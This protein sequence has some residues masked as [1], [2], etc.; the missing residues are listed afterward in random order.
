MLYFSFFLYN[1]ELKQII[2]GSYEKIFIRE[3]SNPVIGMLRLNI[4]GSFSDNGREKVI[5]EFIKFVST[6]VCIK[7]YL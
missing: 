1:N 4:Q 7:V 3:G 2:I 5:V 6:L